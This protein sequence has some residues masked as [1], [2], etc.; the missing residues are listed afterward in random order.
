VRD[1]FSL[2]KGKNVSPDLGGLEGSGLLVLNICEAKGEKRGWLVWGRCCLL[3]VLRWRSLWEGV[4]QGFITTT[5]KGGKIRVG[6][7]G[8][9]FQGKGSRLFLGGALK[10]RS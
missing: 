8:T 3:E 10:L 4:R 5:L 7:G 2:W 6:R 9:R 1:A